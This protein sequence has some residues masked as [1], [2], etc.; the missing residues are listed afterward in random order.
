[1]RNVAVSPTLI[2][3][4]FTKYKYDSVTVAGNDLSEYV[5]AVDPADQTALDLA[6]TLESEFYRRAGYIIEKKDSAIEGLGKKVVVR[7]V[8]NAGI[9][10]FRVY[11]GTRG[12][13]IIECAYSNAFKSAFVTF[14]NE[15]FE[16]NTKKNVEFDE[17]FKYTVH[18]SSVKY[19]DFGAKGDGVTDDFTAIAMAHEY[20]NQGGQTVYAD[21]GATYY[22]GASSIGRTIGVKTNTYFGNA[23]FIIDDTILPPN[24]GNGQHIKSN[25]FLIQSSKA[26][27]NVPAS[28]LEGLTFTKGQANVGLTFEGKSLLHVLSKERKIYIRWGSNQNNGQD[29]QE[30]ILVEADGTVDAST[31]I[32][33]DY[34][35]VSSITVYS[36]DDAPLII[37]GGKFITWANQLSTFADGGPY[38]NGDQYYYY[39]RGIMVRRSNVTVDGV[40]HYVEKEGEHGYP[41]SAFYS[42]SNCNNILIQNCIMTGH[43]SYCEDRDGT[44]KS[45][46]RVECTTCGSVKDGIIQKSEI[47]SGT[48]MGS[49]DIGGSYANNITWKNCVQSNFWKNESAGTVYS[50]QQDYWGIM[51]TNYCKNLTYDGCTLSRFDAHCGVYNAVV[52]DSLISY[53]INSVGM[54]VFLIENTTILTGS[55]FLTLRSDYGSTWDGE[56]IVKNSTLTAS[57]SSYQI[58]NGSWKDWE[59]GYVCHMPDVTID[60]IKVGRTGSTIYATYY[61]G[62][63]NTTFTT[64]KNAMVMPTRNVIVKNL[65][66]GMTVSSSNVQAVR[67]VIGIDYQ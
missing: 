55:K 52:K 37:S 31:P 36:A 26:S 61:S 12:D 40:D 9:D 24:S 8:A 17:E 47:D 27:Y 42:V 48:T 20:A 67:S 3:Q 29:Q 66:A 38:L 30:V 5:I 25:I 13:L 57:S 28:E 23:T 43:K 33:W 51:G 39:S 21:D 15:Y 7:S 65:S 1:M 62:T 45:H 59:F 35:M 46:Q 63:N 2:I 53:T 19:S 6:T 16:Y 11:V 18:V 22:I 50:E 41:Y 49:Y 58:V 54:G 64:S 34:S 60:G 4:E 44:C 56:V 14:F 10:G 32:M